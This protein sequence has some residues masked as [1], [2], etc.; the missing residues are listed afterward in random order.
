MMDLSDASERLPRWLDENENDFECGPVIPVAIPIFITLIAAIGLFANTIV[1]FIVT[2]LREYTKSVT[3][4]YVLQLAIADF[5]F[6]FQLPFQART[7][8]IGQ[9]TYGV[10]WCK[11]SEGIKML[12]YYSSIMFLTIM[13]VDR[14]L[15]INFAMNQKV[16][17]VR[18]KRA[19]FVISSILWILS[20]VS[21]VNILIHADVRGCDCQIFFPGVEH[22][23][24]NITHYLSNV[25]DLTDYGSSDY[26]GDYGVVD[27]GSNSTF[28]YDE[29][30]K[31]ILNDDTVCSFAKPQ[32]SQY[33]KTW[34]VCNFVLA[35]AVPLV[36]ICVSYALI[37]R[38][39]LKPMVIG[40]KSQK[41]NKTRKRV[42][43][44]V[45]ALVSA[46][47]ICWLP[48]HAFHL[49]RLNDVRMFAQA[50]E[51]ISNF[52]IVLAYSNSAINPF[53]Y[54]F[55]GTNFRRRWGN[56]VGKA[57]KGI[58]QSILS[59]S[60]DYTPGSSMKMRRKSSGVS[61]SGA[62][63]KNRD[64]ASSMN[65]FVTKHTIVP[66]NNEIIDEEK[67]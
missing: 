5:I 57:R 59:H 47:I 36:I 62:R 50:C 49:A 44:M 53:F 61:N 3:N 7:M 56:A 28:D 48:Y 17:K 21:V 19:A 43:I 32:Y 39:I 34:I 15:A 66:V 30:L 27:Y 37:I 63:D 46:F 51:N 6:L 9:W 24:Q 13:S 23:H 65:S 64:D 1:I 42:T 8:V 26:S 2:V 31:E 4:I 45:T 25:S 22:L 20:F 18:T 29:Y 33:F 52:T 35:F 58:R 38:R 54:T 16:A 55:L 12:N 40:T 11:L 41:S 14:Y 10:L 67:V 60:G